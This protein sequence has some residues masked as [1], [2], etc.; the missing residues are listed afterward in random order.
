MAPWI[1]LAAVSGAVLLVLLIAGPMLRRRVMLRTATRHAA[2]QPD[3]DAKDNV[4]SLRAALAKA[5][6]CIAQRDAM[7]E[8]Q[9]AEIARQAATM[10]KLRDALAEVW[11][12]PEQASTDFARF[13]RLRTLIV[14]EL[15]PDHAAKNGADRAARTELFKAIWPKVEEITDNV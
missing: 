1:A 4:R 12:S 13:K 2:A 14:M 15:H 5:E 9:A 6:D 3:A 8:R 7:V 10:E 11:R